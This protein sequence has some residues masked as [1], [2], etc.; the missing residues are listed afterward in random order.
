LQALIDKL[1]AMAAR[2]LL[3]R[4][5]AD[6]AHH[7][8]AS[9]LATGTGGSMA[10]NMTGLAVGY[11][12]SMILTRLLGVESYGV[13]VTAANL[14]NVAYVVLCRGY[15]ISSLRF[16]PSYLDQGDHGHLRGFLRAAPRII[17]LNSALFLMLA[18]A[19]VWLARPLYG[20]EMMLCLLAAALL[21]PLKALA[22]YLGSVLR[23]LKQAARSI[24]YTRVLG[25]VLLGSAVLL[26]WLLPGVSL[27]A[28][29]AMSANVAGTL[30]LV[31]I[32]A[33][34]LRREEAFSGARGAEPLYERAEWKRVAA[35]LLVINI[36][37]LI[38]VRTDIQM[39]TMLLGPAEAGI[40]AIAGQLAV[41]VMFVLNS[42]NQIL[43]PQI[44]ELHRREDKAGLQS[45]MTAAARG[46]LA[47]TLPVVLVLVIAGHWVLG[48]YGAAYTAGYNAMLILAAG[49]LTAVAAGPVGFLMNMTGGHRESAW[50]I[51][52]TALVNV[53]LNYWLIGR[54]GIEGAALASS[55]VMALRTVLLT[56]AARRRLGISSGVFA[57]WR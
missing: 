17:L 13:Y 55:S 24:F 49:Q 2:L 39:I 33:R 34:L 16:I 47:L 18:L 41:L 51:G 6:S 29:L 31:L 28:P 46:I 22:Q 53:G 42:A 1:G 57:L 26:L 25:H 48:W 56:V 43:A 5:S 3:G 9:V 7:R 23:S 37:Q 30:V 45:L 14:V 20:R 8:T 40:Y 54:M 38:L 21:T 15:D 35:P 44:T 50:V 32:V 52:V 11:L 19:A 27:S 12:A 4:G 10:A 36:F